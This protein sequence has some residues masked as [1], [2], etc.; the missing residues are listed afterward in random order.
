MNLSLCVIL[1]TLLNN[2]LTYCSKCYFL[3]RVL[4]P[5][6]LHMCTMLAGLLPHRLPHQCCSYSRM[7]FTR[8]VPLPRLDAPRTR[9]HSQAEILTPRRF[10]AHFHN[11]VRGVKSRNRKFKGQEEEWKARNKTVLTYIAAA[12]VGM[13]GLSYAAVPLYRLYCQVCWKKISQ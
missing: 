10:P 11:Q 2:T 4:P 3:H 6:Y 13:I 1:L 5:G 9:L 12:G 7:L 8:C